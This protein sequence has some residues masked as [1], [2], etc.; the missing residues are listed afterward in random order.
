MSDVIKRLLKEQEEERMRRTEHD[1]KGETL[2]QR[3]GRKLVVEELK[4]T[5]KKLQYQLDKV[6]ARLNLFPDEEIIAKLAA[7]ECECVT[8]MDPCW[9][10]CELEYY[11]EDSKD[12]R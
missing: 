5:N 4:K 1:A 3:M 2:V 11:G 8:P 9:R 6:K 12:Y 10:C 7:C